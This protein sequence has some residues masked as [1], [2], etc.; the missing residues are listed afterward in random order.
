MSVLDMKDQIRKA[1]KTVAVQWPT[2][3][4]EDDLEQDIYVHLLER[5]GSVEKLLTEFADKDRFNAIIAIGHQIAAKERTDYE[6]FS[7][8]FRYSVNEVRNL[9]EKRTFE[10]ANL[11]RTST[12]GDLL[13]GIN[14]IG[15]TH[16]QIIQRKYK[17]GERITT[18]A[19]R[20]LLSEALTALTTQMNRSFKSTR[21]DDGP[22]S[23]KPV[24]AGKAHYQSK[25]N[26]DDESSEAINRLLTQ[27]RASGR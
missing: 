14:Q 10:D 12:S 15:E 6:V 21:R 11:S 1:A 3:V 19:E 22:G 4:D 27:A 23:R 8:N 7:G 18:G 9:L 17:A 24:T 2:V 13:N 26:W 5:P 20:T 25:K 16:R